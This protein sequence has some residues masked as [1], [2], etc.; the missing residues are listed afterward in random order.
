MLSLHLLLLL[1]SLLHRP[2]HQELHRVNGVARP[3][4]SP[5]RLCARKPPDHLLPEYAQPRLALF[6]ADYL[7]HL[8]P[9]S[10]LTPF[11]LQMAR[12]THSRWPSLTT[13]LWSSM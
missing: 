1:L 4:V 12:P 7:A 10:L 13:P 5:G 3:G 2:Q 9:S 6:L 8:P 11:L